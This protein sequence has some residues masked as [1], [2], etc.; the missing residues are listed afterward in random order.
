MIDPTAPCR[1]L[2]PEAVDAINQ[3]LLPLVLSA[4]LDGRR[5]DLACL[6]RIR[7]RLRAAPVQGGEQLEDRVGRVAEEPDDN[8]WPTCTNCN[9]TGHPYIDCGNEHS[10]YNYQG[11]CDCPQGRAMRRSEAEKRGGWD[12]AADL[13]PFA[14]RPVVLEPLDSTVTMYGH[15]IR[16]GVK[17]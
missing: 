7:H 16:I 14:V 8:L 15:R 11:F 4:E 1:I 2:S 10:D 9:N 13:D 5:A 12:I 17:R 3:D 6:T